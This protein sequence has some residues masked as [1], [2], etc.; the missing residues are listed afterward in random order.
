MIKKH[1]ILYTIKY[2][3]LTFYLIGTIFLLF[4]HEDIVQYIMNLFEIKV[5]DN[6]YSLISTIIN[7]AIWGLWIY[8]FF[9][10]TRNK[11]YFYRT[12][13]RYGYDHGRYHR[14]YGALV[15][16]FRYDHA[17]PHRL[18]TSVFSVAKWQNAKGIVFGRD[19][20]RLIAIPSDSEC[21]IAVFGP[22]GSGKTAGIAIINAIT[23]AGS[24]LAV[25][26]K[27][28]LYNYVSTH[29]NRKI[30]R[31]CPDSPNALKESVRFDPLEHINEMNATECKLYIESM[32]TVLIPDT[33]SNDGNYFTSRAR[34]MFQGITHLMLNNNP[35]TSFPEI[36]H[37]I[38]Q[39][40]IFDWV[41]QAM[42]SDCEP[43]KELL[44]SFYGNSEKNVSSAYDALNT[45]LIN[46]S[47]SVLDQLLDRH[48]N[49]CVSIKD[50]EA[51]YDIY[52]QISQEHLDAYAPLFTLLI[53]SFSTG[54]TRRADSSTG[55]KNRPCLMLLDEFPQLTFSYQLIN[56]NLSTLRSK[57]VIIMIIQQNLSQLEYRFQPTGSR[58]ILGNCN[59][60]IILGSNDI[61][62]SKLF[63]DTFGTKKI[64][65]VSNSVNLGQGKTSGKNCQELDEKVFPPEYFGD[66]SHNSKMI[67]YFK[68]KYCECTKLNCYKD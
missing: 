15:D 68:G 9:T 3:H 54:F 55:V 49:N 30:K 44:S 8:I 25:D 16:Y 39:G 63:S 47:N 14:S 57:S 24:V 53:Q 5:W 27:G 26:I 23:F 4:F 11:M 41:T 65:K 48:S 60:Q 7:G 19:G 1:G 33:N 62:S 67:L 17:E 45:S 51:G 10:N 58:S 22:P 56:A 36:I 18:D 61:N 20:K 38:L 28:D 12:G 21:N 37:A 29:S 66:L 6:I 32:A 31:F 2:Y 43:A 40:N 46:F 35:D 64:L 52:L 42:E 59:Y 34:K 13:R 50:I